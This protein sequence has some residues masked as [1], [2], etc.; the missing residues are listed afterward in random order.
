MPQGSNVSDLR[1]GF[2]A[3]GWFMLTV[4][5]YLFSIYL[6][7][8]F[9][10]TNPRPGF[11]ECPDFAVHRP[12]ALDPAFDLVFAYVSM[13]L[14]SLATNGPACPTTWRQPNRGEIGFGFRCAR[15]LFGIYHRRFRPPPFVQ[16]AEQR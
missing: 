10:D 5:C 7:L 15:L 16:A 6:T 9:N 2:A 12:S 3:T 14:L 13:Y 8:G 4:L 11:S 1:A